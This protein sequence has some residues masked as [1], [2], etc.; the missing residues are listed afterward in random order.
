MPTLNGPHLDVLRTRY[1]HLATGE[2]K[3][4]NIGESFRMG[5]TLGKKGIPNWVESWGKEWDHDW[6]TWRA[7]LPKY[8]DEWTQP[9]AAAKQAEAG[10]RG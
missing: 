2:G 7:K 10:A 9:G 6:V 8:L 5:Q 4:E 1:I 3:W